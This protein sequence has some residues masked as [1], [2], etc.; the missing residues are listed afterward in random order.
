MSTISST[1][2][3][4]LQT[5][6]AA[7]DVNA[8]GTVSKSELPDAISEDST[9]AQSIVDAADSDG[10]GALS[11]VEYSTFSATFA[12]ATGLSLLTAQ[13][14]VTSLFAAGDSDGSATLSAD[15]LATALTTSTTAADTTTTA[16]TDDGETGGSD[17][18]T[19]SADVQAALDA[20]DATGDSAFDARDVAVGVLQ[21]ADEA[22]RK[23][24]NSSKAD[25]SLD[26]NGD[27][28][29]SATELASAILKA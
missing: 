17:D 5:Q 29:I 19:L 10:D 1:T 16:S 24:A 15:E 23:A 12:N 28:T 8:D 11:Q 22:L 4:S 14:S 6:L 7:A 3:T 18:T 27:G 26:T 25:A 21:A 9:L 13:E 2:W 20:V